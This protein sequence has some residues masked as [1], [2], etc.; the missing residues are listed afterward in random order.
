MMHPRKS[1]YYATKG[2]LEFLM[3]LQKF[4]LHLKQF[5]NYMWKLV[6]AR[7]RILMQLLRYRF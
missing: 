3:S 6:M 1:C 7:K 2:V 5:E 4:L